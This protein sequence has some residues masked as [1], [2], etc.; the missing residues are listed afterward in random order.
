MHKRRTGCARRARRE[1]RR[2]WRGDAEPQG[3]VNDVR[4]AP[5]TLALRVPRHRAAGPAEDFL[6]V[7][8]DGDAGGETASNRRAALC[9]FPRRR[10]TGRP[11]WVCI[12]LKTS[13]ALL[14]MC[15]DGGM[16]V[17]S[18]TEKNEDS[19]SRWGVGKG[20]YTSKT[21][22]ARRRNSKFRRRARAAALKNLRLRT[23]SR[24]WTAARRCSRGHGRSHARLWARPAAVT[25]DANPSRSTYRATARR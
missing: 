3:V 19:E 25:R 23:G 17:A 1:L 16:V 9:A 14:C 15:M 21:E 2:L 20:E 5:R 4:S 18:K 10:Q 6:E 24:R 8:G 13:G 12:L 11:V 7:V 22:K